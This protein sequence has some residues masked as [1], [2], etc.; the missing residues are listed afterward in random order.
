ML[1]YD[2]RGNPDPAWWIGQIREGETWRDEVTYKTQW[3]TWRKYYR[4]QWASGTLPINFFFA[5]LRSMV[6][7][8]Y[9][10]NPAVS[11]TPEKPGF[12][13]MAF[14]RVIGRI[15]N[16]LIRQMDVRSAAKTMVQNTF[17]FGTGVGKLGFGG[18]F[19]FGAS[20][21]GDNA[22]PILK[23]GE[24]LEY[25]PNV[26]PNMPWFQS[27]HPGR[28]VVPKGLTDYKH[29]RWVAEKFERVLDD[30]ERDPRLD[31]RVTAGL[32]A[33][34]VNGEEQPMVEGYEIRDMKTGRVIVLAASGEGTD[35]RISG[36]RALFVGTDRLIQEFGFNYYPIVF[37]PDDEYFWG[38]PDSKILE[39][40]QLEANE[41]RT[42]MMKH[43]RLS[44]VKI[45]AKKG[46][47][48][49]SEAEKLLSSDVAPI[50]N[51][52]AEF[53]AGSIDKLTA[54][55]IPQSLVVM[56]RE[57]EQDVR[58]ILGL[59]KNQMGEF[60]SRRGDTTAA[61]VETVRES[62]DI[63]V[64]EKRDEM[65]QMLTSMVKKMNGILFE[66]WSGQQVADV[67]GPGGATVWVKFNPASLKMAHYDVRI[68][69]DTST[70]RTRQQ[71]E[72]KAAEV[73]NLLK[74][75]PLIDPTALTQ[76]LLN[77]LEGVEMDT[78]MR[79]LPAVP[80]PG[81]GVTDLGGFASMLQQSMG[82]LRAGA[83]PG[84]P[85]TAALLAAQAGA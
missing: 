16:K 23:N 24:R 56:M 14:A 78:L 63:R 65:A 12:L 6:P 74:A 69:P 70:P 3:N 19:S 71:R 79:A 29:A 57:M 31:K 76:Y 55:D 30:M 85:Q 11:V 80:Q 5:Y 53:T 48:S 15:D 43:R 82:R 42:L 17:L 8:I 33:S 25:H 81:G 58:M 13:E 20:P 32:V 66:R 36:P 54:A 34:K 52:E 47:I 41:T 75:N 10:R 77:E 73:Y 27:V 59:S 61:E 35:D 4:G 39:P 28:F 62:S 44:I 51:V 22:A 18:E 72:Q 67:I 84:N 64:D 9:F 60:A 68:D 37:N 40:T 45:L 46:V 26:L 7:R 38:I 50:V 49:Q 2:T 1:G 83:P 21:S